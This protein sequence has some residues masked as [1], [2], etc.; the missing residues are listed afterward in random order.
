ML[1]SIWGRCF[2]IAFVMLWLMVFVIQPFDLDVL[3]RVNAKEAEGWVSVAQIEA[4]MG[5]V[6]DTG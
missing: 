1:S 4:P 5:K 3:L 6:Y 2:G